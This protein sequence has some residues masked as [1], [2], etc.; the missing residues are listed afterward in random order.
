MKLRNNFLYNFLK[1]V[2]YKYLAYRKYPHKWNKK[3]NYVSVFFGGEEYKFK[4]FR[5]KRKMY[6]KPYYLVESIPFFWTELPGYIAKRKL[7]KGDYVLDLGAFHGAFTIYA[8]KKVGMSGRVYAFEP[9]K[10]NL[11]ILMENLKLNNCKNV[12]V[13][14]KGVWNKKAFL[15]FSGTGL[16]GKIDK[17]G[18][19]VIE[20]TDLD[21]ELKRMKINPK[22][23]SFI[24]M[25]IEGAEIEAL[26]GMRDLLKIGN[27]FLAIASYHQRDGEQTYKKIEKILKDLGYNVKTGYPKHLTTWAWKDG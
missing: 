24:K 5:E 27:P 13:I 8:S 18:E 9:E 19:E 21:S 3:E 14:K 15:H 23:I 25:D 17:T 6:T 4:L 20:V 26:N 10:G 11:N 7:Q 12:K 2:Y 1:E 16:G 22:R